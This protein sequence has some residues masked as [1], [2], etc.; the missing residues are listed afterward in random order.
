MNTRATN[1][2]RSD[3][4]KQVKKKAWCNTGKLLLH[5]KELIRWY[6]HLNIITQDFDILKY[7]AVK[8]WDTG[9]NVKND[10]KGSMPFERTEREGILVFMWDE[11]WAF[12][13]ILPPPSLFPLNTSLTTAPGLYV[14]TRRS[15]LLLNCTH[16]IVIC[17]S[18]KAIEK[19][20][21]PTKQKWD[22]CIACT[23]GRFENIH[24][25][26][27]VMF[28]NQ[29]HTH[30]WGRYT[31]M[32]LGEYYANGM[33]VCT[34]QFTLIFSLMP[35]WPSCHHFWPLIKAC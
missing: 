17:C 30:C 22:A 32:N 29:D 33:K 2:K 15:A 26:Y 4:R 3:I 25:K 23:T 19:N 18:S 24:I 35:C 21:H 34:I 16:N 1:K 20:S 7:T 10:A 28:F 27:E 11:M 9:R 13:F 8:G 31:V 6:H 5:S 14:C 12:W